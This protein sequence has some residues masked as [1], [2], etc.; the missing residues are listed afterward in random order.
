MNALSR[1]IDV[2]RPGARI[3]DLQVIRPD[4]C[5]EL[6][7]HAIVRVDGSP[8]FAWAD[9][10]VAAIAA[11]IAA[12]HLVEEGAHDHDVLTHYSDGAELVDDIAAS[13]RS[14]PEQDSPGLRALAQPLVVRERCRTRLL[15]VA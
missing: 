5:V 11:E 8:L 1:M 2:A 3:L 6:D 14:I 13:R 9:A 12:G 4:P 7:G 15:R 10:A